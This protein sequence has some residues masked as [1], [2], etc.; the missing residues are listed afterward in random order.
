MAWRLGAERLRERW[1]P[2]AHG[3]GLVIGDVVDAGAVV[4]EGEY[5]RCGGVVEVDE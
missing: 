4:F 1:Q 2:F 5:G 3:G